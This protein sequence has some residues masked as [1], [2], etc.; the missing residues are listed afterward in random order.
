MLGVLQEYQHR[1]TEA[2]QNEGLDVLISP[3]MPYPALPLGNSDLST[4]MYCL[5][6]NSVTQVV[7]R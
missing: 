5:F 3:P 4:R 1:V 7:S 2:W 6:S